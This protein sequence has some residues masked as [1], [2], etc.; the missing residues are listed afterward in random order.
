MNAKIVLTGGGSAGHVTPNLAMIENL[1]EE[2]WQIDY[3]GSADGVEKQIIGKTRV[4]FHPI[5]SGKLRRYF[6]WQNFLDPFKIVYGLIQSFWLLRRLNTDLVFSKGGFVAFP[7]VVAAW[8]NRIPVVAHE[9]DMS[10]GLA[11]RLCLPFVNKLCVT[12]AP[13]KNHVKRQDKVAIT[14]TPIRRQLFNGSRQRGLALC[15]FNDKQA[16]LLVIGGS[17][18]AQ[19]INQA[20]REALPRLSHNYQIIHLCGK[21]KVDESLQTAPG[22][23][24]L[25]YASDE[26]ADLFAAADVVV[27]RAG[28]NALYEIL[29]LQKPHV[30]IPL[31]AKVSRGDQIQNA[32]Y[33]K[34]QGISIVIPQEELTTDRL[35]MA[36]DEAEANQQDIIRRI[37]S[38]KIESATVK[39]MNLIKEQLHV[40]SPETV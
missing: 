22:Y 7:V 14:G 20:V 40:E 15:G 33:F 28:A 16:I 35:L 24:Q 29:A 8:L 6:S 31:S 13:A 3:I 10:P 30:L 5:Q 23:F 38:L 25:E 11:N 26:L 17:L 36:I 12:F 32:G 27:S 39:I 21:G 18:G 34:E 19:A 9:S 2:G 1:E 4:P 37:K